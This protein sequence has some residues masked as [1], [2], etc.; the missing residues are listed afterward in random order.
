M[1]KSLIAFDT[2]HIKGYVFRAGGLKEIRGASSILDELNRDTMCHVAEKTYDA[3][4][5]YANGG[6]G[7]FLIDQDMAD[8]CGREVQ[9]KYLEKSKGTASVTYAVQD[10][11]AKKS[12][13]KVQIQDIDL[14]EE[15]ELLRLELR[16]KKD[17]SPDY[18]SVPSHP[19]FHPCEVCGVEYA[20]LISSQNDEEEPCCDSC[21]AKQEEDITI[22]ARIHNTIKHPQ[23]RGDIGRQK[24]WERII[25][26]LQKENY[27]FRSKSSTSDSNSTIPDRPDDF[28]ELGD[29][30]GDR[31]MALIYADGNAMGR[32]VEQQTTLRKLATFAHL[33]DDAV[34]IA[35]SKAIAR[36]LKVKF[37]DKPPIFPFD[38][39]L[40]GGD[41]IVMVTTT[42][43]ALDIA[44]TIAE[45]FRR[46]TENRYDLSVGVV[47][48]PVK[49]PF[50][51][52]LEMSE[53]ALKF[54]K[55]KA[56]DAR[57]KSA[58]D[59][60]FDASR[61]NF[62]VVTGGTDPDFKNVYEQIYHVTDEKDEFIA[63]QRPYTPQDLRK[64]LQQI[65][66]GRSKYSLGRTKLHQLRD[67][68]FEMNLSTSVSKG[69]ATLVSWR[70][71]PRSFVVQEVYN[72]GLQRMPLNN[73]ADPIHGFPR[74]IFPW[75][76]ESRSK[77]DREVYCTPLLDF[78]E[79]YDFVASEGDERGAEN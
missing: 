60:P 40:L 43:H 76:R 15:L 25:Y 51:L 31:Y 79:L 20:N 24:L 2:D 36:Y 44:A 37:G 74:V 35:M 63:T 16:R 12:G 27:E 11:P 8:K 9:R 19:F 18:L 57:A 46:A 45:E 23:R 67:A 54:A 53:S 32:A 10:L 77:D 33:I 78:I 28:N 17:T 41:D 4:L 48:A 29:L 7:L 30:L 50:S 21:K 26:Y 71:K 3:E 34:H 52:L 62:L 22:K 72:A 5:I 64:L 56:A 61:I 14:S 75:Y 47:L 66:E 73:P 59:T 6:G 68:I 55:K 65:R 69:L 1:V 42:E 39:L 38:I 13:T 70:E 49:Y 58:K